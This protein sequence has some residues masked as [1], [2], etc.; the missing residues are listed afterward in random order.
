MQILACTEKCKLVHGYQN[1]PKVKKSK[2]KKGTR[3]PSELENESEFWEPELSMSAKMKKEQ[4]Q[5]IK[6]E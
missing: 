4:R 6:G 1:K 2:G 5:K 3:A